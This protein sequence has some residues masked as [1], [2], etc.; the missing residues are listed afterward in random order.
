MKES[1]EMSVIWSIFEF[2]TSKLV[3]NLLLVNRISYCTGKN[4]DKFNRKIIPFW[5]RRTNEKYHANF[6][7]ISATLFTVFISDLRYDRI[8][9]K[10]EINEFRAV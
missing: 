10:K 1:I 4:R 5:K 8:T 6:I 9:M 7:S 3:D 2:F